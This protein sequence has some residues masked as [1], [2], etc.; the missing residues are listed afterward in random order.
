MNAERTE[1][2]AAPLVWPSEPSPER[3][4][5][6]VLIEAI[7]RGLRFRKALEPRLRELE[8]L[9]ASDRLARCR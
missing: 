8:M 7:Q 3:V 9:D 1:K 6:S 5:V 2:T 4:D